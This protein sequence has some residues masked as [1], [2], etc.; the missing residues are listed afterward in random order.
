MNGGWQRLLRNHPWTW[1]PAL[2]VLVISLAIFIFYQIAYAGRVEALQ[3][4]FDSERAE[5][6]KRSAQRQELASYLERVRASRGGISELYLD[7]FKTPADRLTAVLG[8][9]QK[10]ARA[11]GLDPPSFSYPYE[12]VGDFELREMG[13]NFQVAG[14]YEQLRRF[15]NLIELT[16][17]FLTLRAVK[18]T[19]VSGPSGA[20]PQLGISLSAS[21]V[22]VS[23]ALADSASRA[24]AGGVQGTP[25]RD[26]APASD[27]DQGAEKEDDGETPAEAV[28]GSSS[29]ADT[30]P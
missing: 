30:A 3:R 28:A 16:D 21:T 6:E 26:E 14:T 19:S 15:I 23:E 1:G 27:V 22:F 11:A 17:Q 8:E 5:L 29:V 24:R 10:L 13:I 7:Y 12:A 20:S 9:I 25:A 2:G 18:L 4:R